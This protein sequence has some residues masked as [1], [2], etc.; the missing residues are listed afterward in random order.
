MSAVKLWK[1]ITAAALV[2]SGCNER[3]CVFVSDWPTAACTI[4]GWSHA[5]PASPQHVCPH[6]ASI[7]LVNAGKRRPALPQSGRFDRKQHSA[8][9]VFSFLDEREGQCRPCVTLRPA[10]RPAGITNFET[11]SN[12]IFN[13]TNWSQSWVSDMKELRWRNE[14][15]PFVFN[16]ASVEN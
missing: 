15:H 2:W 4:Q 13:H 11:D 14:G 8:S 5:R 10:Q 7:S 12:P 6:A 9:C 3:V 16:G 1:A